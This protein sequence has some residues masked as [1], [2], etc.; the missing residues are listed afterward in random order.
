LILPKLSNFFALA[1]EQGDLNAP[2]WLKNVNACV[3]K[4]DTVKGK[5]RL[6][7]FRPLMCFVETFFEMERLKVA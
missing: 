6:R 7:D 4:A 3:S 2:A 1:V 5:S